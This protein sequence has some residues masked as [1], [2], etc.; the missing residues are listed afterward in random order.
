MQRRKILSVFYQ[1]SKKAFS[2]AE[3]K[4]WVSLGAHLQ[5]T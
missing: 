3:E 2:L 1:E 4:T 5:K